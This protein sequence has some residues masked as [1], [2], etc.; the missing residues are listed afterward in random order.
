MTCPFGEHDN[1]G[2]WHLDWAEVTPEEIE[3]IEAHTLHSWYAHF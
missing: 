2:R 1:R 3:L